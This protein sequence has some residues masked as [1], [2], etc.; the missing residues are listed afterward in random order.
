MSTVTII[1]TLILD[2][3]LICDG[4]ISVD[5]SGLVIPVPGE[6]MDTYNVCK[7]SDE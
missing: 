2:G 5:P 6:V 1:G 7:E 4:D 3:N